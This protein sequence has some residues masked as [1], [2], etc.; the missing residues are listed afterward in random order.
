MTEP[1]SDFEK[2][3]VRTCKVVMSTTTNSKKSNNNFKKKVTN[4]DV[5]LRCPICKD[6]FED[7]VM[8]QGCSH[9]FC[10]K[11]I[12]RSLLHKTECPVCKTK[13]VIRSHLHA[14][15]LIT[16]LLDAYKLQKKHGMDEMCFNINDNN[17]KSISKF[18]TQS[19]KSMKSL[20]IN[21]NN[22]CN[23]IKTNKF[24]SNSNNKSLACSKLK[25][26]KSKSKSNNN[27]IKNNIQRFMNPITKNKNGQKNTKKNNKKRKANVL[28]LD[29][30][31]QPP[32]N[33]RKVTN[34]KGNIGNKGNTVNC[35]ICGKLIVDS[36]INSHIDKCLSITPDSPN[37]DNNNHNNKTDIMNKE[38]DM[39]SVIINELDVNINQDDDDE[40]D[41][42]DIIS[43]GNNHNKNHNKNI[44]NNIMD[45]DD[46]EEEELEPLMRS[47]ED[48]PIKAMPYTAYEHMNVKDLK[49][50][51]EKLRLNKNGDKKILIKRHKEFILRHNSQID[52]WMNGNDIMNDREIAREINNEE[53][54]KIHSNFFNKSNKNKRNSQKDKTKQ[55]ER[56]KKLIKE[57]NER[58]GVEYC[59]KRRK[60][61]RKRLKLRQQMTSKS[62]NCD[63]RDHKSHI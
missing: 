45:I 26:S 18:N 57:L 4:M 35:P 2:K 13:Q 50:I 6:Y 24:S 9:N 22:K 48:C 27:N 36:F 38:C 33:R 41:D 42:I 16:Q 11:C 8:I 1:L 61:R 63:N 58:M 37:I 54:R 10:S 31:Y 12:R 62:D 56:F 23:V 32:K 25:T 34:N 44:E 17:H 5:L 49:K 20:T 52:R 47:K 46:K 39:K 59:R 60:Y 53:T 7:P 29:D 28:E 15:N 14:N 21:G 19:S 43:N 40:E 55:E 3:R 30:E 51:V